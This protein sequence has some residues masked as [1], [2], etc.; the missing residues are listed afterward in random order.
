MNKRILL[1]E[2][3]EQNRYLVTYLLQ[4]RGWE[5]S[6]AIDG[7]AGL[8]M[9]NEIDPALILLDIQLP[10]MD[11][12]AVARALRENAKLDGIP[13]VAVT[14][15]AMAGDRERCIESGCDGYLEKPIDPQTFAAQVEQFVRTQ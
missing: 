11:G 8:S 3:N 6:H 10:G 2:D 9:A 14:S 13:V 4:A 7:A 15:Y 12:Y 1:I 5:V